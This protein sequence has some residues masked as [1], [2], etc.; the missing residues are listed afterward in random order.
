MKGPAKSWGGEPGHR[1]FAALRMTRW[2][3][4]QGGSAGKGEEG[5]LITDVGHDERGYG[6]P[7]FVILR[8]EGSSQAVA[9]SGWAQIL[10]AALRMT[11]MLAEE[12]GAFVEHMY[13]NPGLMIAA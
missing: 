7:V 2:I 8:N 10:R 4:E 11:T 13:D 5:C 3:G 1:S 9:S 12:I 6:C